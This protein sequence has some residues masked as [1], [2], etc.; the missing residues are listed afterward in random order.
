MSPIPFNQSGS[1]TRTFNKLCIFQFNTGAWTLNNERAM[2]NRIC[3][4]VIHLENY[5]DIDK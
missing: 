3:I 4:Y 5:V 2:L 1:F